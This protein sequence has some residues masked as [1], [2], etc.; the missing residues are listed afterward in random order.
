MFLILP[1]VGGN[2]F[3]SLVAEI[4]TS[5]EKKP[6]AFQPPTGGTRPVAEPKKAAKVARKQ[7]RPEPEPEDEAEVMKGVIAEI[8][9]ENPGL[10]EEQCRE[11]VRH[12]SS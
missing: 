2:L 5:Q 1:V 11:A 10:S 12:S 9:A 8:M 7:G 4:K 3:E 6:R